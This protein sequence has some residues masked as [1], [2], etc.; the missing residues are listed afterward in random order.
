ML[1][2]GRG[3]RSPSIAPEQP[4]AHT[5]AL[6]R[7]SCPVVGPRLRTR[8]LAVPNTESHRPRAKRRGLLAVRG[9]LASGA[10]AIEQQCVA[11]AAAGLAIRPGRM[12][13]LRQPEPTSDA[14]LG[15][16]LSSAEQS[17]YGEARCCRSGYSNSS[18]RTRSR[19]SGDWCLRSMRPE[20]CN[21]YGRHRTAFGR[22]P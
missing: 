21:S 9:A 20:L 16:A 12:S 15:R 10:V 19:S 4:A 18:R 22:G 3:S 6:R 8:A 2:I 11:R 1:R 7:D 17:A 5:S 14:D 13:T